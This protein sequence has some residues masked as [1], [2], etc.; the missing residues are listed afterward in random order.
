MITEVL[1]VGVEPVAKTANQ[2]DVPVT[3]SDVCRGRH[4]K[5]RRQ[6]VRNYRLIGATD[7]ITVCK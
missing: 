5:Q 1:L 7:S 6:N 2:L 3:N 4:C